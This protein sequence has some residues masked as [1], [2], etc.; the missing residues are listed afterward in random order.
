MK[1]H[2]ISIN[3]RHYSMIQFKR[4]LLIF[5]A[6]WYVMVSSLHCLFDSRITWDTLLGSSVRVFPGHL[7]KEG[8]SI[9]T[10]WCLPQTEVPC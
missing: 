8:C 6:L 2:T 9:R 10:R 3:V 7:T 5:G 4:K 1:I